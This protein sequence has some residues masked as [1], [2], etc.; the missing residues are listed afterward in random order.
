MPGAATTHHALLS[1]KRLAL[2]LDLDETLLQAVTLRSFDERVD[3]AARKAAACDAPQRRQALEADLARLLADRALLQDYALNDAVTVAG[4]R[5]AAAP[6]PADD[7]AGGPV[8]RPI[9]RLPASGVILTRIDPLRRETSM[10]VR[11]RPGWAD[12]RAFLVGDDRT[13]DAPPGG[14][15]AVPTPRPRFDVFVCTLSEKAYAREVW[16]L[17]DPGARLIAPALRAQRIVATPPER[18]KTLRDA[19]GGAR[20][21]SLSRLALIVDDRPAIWE[22]AAQAQVLAVAP[23]LP[24]ATADGGSEGATGGW[25]LVGVRAGLEAARGSA[26]RH[27]DERFT[28][29]LATLTAHH[30]AETLPSLP[31]V[32]AALRPH[33]ERALHRPAEVAAEGPPGPAGDPWRGDLPAFLQAATAA[34][35][36]SAAQQFAAAATA[37]A[38]APPPGASGRSSSLSTLLAEGGEAALPSST[39]GGGARGSPTELDGAAAPGSLPRSSLGGVHPLHSALPNLPSRP[40]LPAAAP[41]LLAPDATPFQQLRVEAERRGG[42]IDWDTRYDQQGTA[43]IYTAVPYLHGKPLASGCGHSRREAQDVAAGIALAKLRAAEAAGVGAAAP[44]AATLSAAALAR[45]VN[46]AGSP[47]CE[48]PL[49]ASVAVPT[50]SVYWERLEAEAA[51]AA[52]GAPAGGGPSLEYHLAEGGDAGGAGGEAGVVVELWAGRPMRAVA[53]GAGP[54]RKEATQR[55]ALAALRQEGF[56]V[57]EEGAGGAAAAGVKRKS[58]EESSSQA[59]AKR[60]NLLAADM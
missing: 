60:A 1:A 42:A 11:I 38:A 32:A 46:L 36:S 29:K 15:P 10:L 37:A 43:Q 59:A 45:M 40:S 54:G 35:L 8:L 58:E 24:Y 22:E 12:L 39:C 30:G 7:E 18:L 27:V 44:A 2:V 31:H 17:L 55:A 20:E 23:F 47:G 51:S 26:Y 48:K 52:G 19:L 14:A 56:T 28:A 49:T 4:A 13:S 3:A 33:R 53:S 16:R 21:A 9:L 6:E 50:L 5:L 25:P 41:Q 57:C 34:G